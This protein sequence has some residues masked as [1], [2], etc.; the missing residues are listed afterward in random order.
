[1]T[2]AESAPREDAD[3]IVALAFRGGP[4][5]RKHLVCTDRVEVPAVPEN[6]EE[7]LV[8]ML[9]G[10]YRRLHLMALDPYEVRKLPICSLEPGKS[11]PKL[12]KQA[13]GDCQDVSAPAPA[14]SP[15]TLSCG[16]V[17]RAWGPHGVFSEAGRCPL[18]E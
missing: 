15:V 2:R 7:R 4:L 3:T 16:T 11:G 14:D 5:A 13:D 18:P 6:Y 8:E 17:F 12:S 10:A 1:M 9:P